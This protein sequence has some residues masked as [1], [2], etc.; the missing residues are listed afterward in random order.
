MYLTNEGCYLI[1]LFVIETVPTSDIMGNT[2]LELLYYHDVQLPAK[3]K[4]MNYESSPVLHCKSSIEVGI[5]DT[6]FCMRNVCRP[7][8]F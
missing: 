5:S 3:S 2:L 1:T 8:H 4:K 6:R 7:K